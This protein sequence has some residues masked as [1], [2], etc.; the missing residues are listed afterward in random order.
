MCTAIP[1]RNV[2]G[3]AVQTLLKTVVPLQRYLNLDTVIRGSLKMAHLG[4]GRLA[5]IQELHEGSEATLVGK[6]LLFTRT[7]VFQQNPDTAIQKSQLPQTLP[8]HIVMKNN[9][10]EGF[11]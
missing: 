4:N 10:A 6:Q 7:L 2:V 3:V 1:L 11:W 8:Q 5:L 9:V